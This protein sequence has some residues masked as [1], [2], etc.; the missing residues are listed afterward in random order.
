METK[1]T[2]SIQFHS[3][4]HVGTGKGEGVGADAIVSKSTNGLPIWPG[5]SLKGVIRDATVQASALEHNTIKADHILKWFG[6]EVTTTSDS[7]KKEDGS[8]K[9]KIRFQN[10]RGCLRFSSAKC[11]KG[12]E[13]MDFEAWAAGKKGKN[14]TPFFF[15]EI[16]N[17]ALEESGIAKKGA[18]R[19]IELTK[20]ITLYADL[21]IVGID[22][23]NEIFE[24]L[25]Q[26]VFPLVRLMGASRTRGLGQITMSFVS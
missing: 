10:E 23:P 17:V 3:Y 20:P 1:K 2:I 25:Q 13:A 26:D 18:L 11:G 4:W 12:R 6:P 21:E 15:T 22:K 8:S 9:M 24:A 5:K 19:S 16:S 14:L 7:E